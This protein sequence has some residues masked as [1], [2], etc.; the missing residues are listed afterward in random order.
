MFWLNN[1]FTVC[2]R[3]MKTLGSTVLSIGKEPPKRFTETLRKSP[4]QVLLTNPCVAKPQKLD[5]WIH[6]THL[7]KAPNPGQTF[8]RSHDQKVKISQNLRRQSSDETVFQDIQT[9]RRFKVYRSLSFFKYF[10]LFFLLLLKYNCLHF[11][12]CHSPQPQASPLPN[13]DTTCLWFCPC[14]LHICS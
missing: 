8:T 12:H 11:P 1:I 9:I 2:F 10:F 13:L 7:K 5:S 14:V 6:M 3:E 4:Y